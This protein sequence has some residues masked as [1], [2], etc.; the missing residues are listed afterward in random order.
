MGSRGFPKKPRLELLK[1][2]ADKQQ[3][4]NFTPERPPAYAP[5]EPDW[6][7]FFGRDRRAAED[8]HAEWELTVTELVRRGM[9][10]ATDATTVVDYVLCHTRV[11]QCER[12]L[13]ARGMVVQGPNGPCRNPAALL[14]FSYRGTLARLR[15]ELG[16][17]PA[18]RMRLGREEPE[19]PDDDSDLDE[20]PPV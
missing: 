13:S 6:R 1:G 11:L 20:V 17:T 2:A 4:H 7:T 9:V 19:V 5:T 18:A 15:T 3:R 14:L 10:T 8:A 12:R 16:L